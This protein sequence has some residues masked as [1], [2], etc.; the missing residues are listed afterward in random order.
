MKFN[1]EALEKDIDALE[2]ICNDGKK[3]IKQLFSN[4]FEVE[5]SDKKKFDLSKL[6]LHQTSSSCIVKYG[7]AGGNNL[8]SFYRDGT[9]T[10]HAFVDQA[11]PIQRDDT[12][13]IKKLPH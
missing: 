3:G 8:I 9:Y 10:V 6:H 4:H 2:G 7:D 5:F 12:K 11:I 13:G 1:A